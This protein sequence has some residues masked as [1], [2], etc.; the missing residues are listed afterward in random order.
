VE[1]ER[2]EILVTLP[3]TEFIL[4]LADLT[5][6]V[7]RQAI[8]LVGAGET[9]ACF[10]LLRFLGEIHAGFT[11]I[12][13]ASQPFL[14]KEMR[15]KMQTLEQSVKKVEN[16]CYAIEVRG[17]EVPEKYLSGIFAKNVDEQNQHEDGTSVLSF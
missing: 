16:A 8:N 15:M 17:S 5:G 13:V 4:G 14:H 2:R 9:D 3:K 10:R 11:K 6:E 12:K 7:M 1:N